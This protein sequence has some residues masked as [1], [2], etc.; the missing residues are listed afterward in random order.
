MDETDMGITPCDPTFV[1]NPIVRKRKPPQR[2]NSDNAK[3][4]T[5]TLTRREFPELK[6]PVP[7]A[8]PTNVG[9]P[10]SID[11]SDENL[12][13]ISKS[14]HLPAERR[15]GWVLAWIIETHFNEQVVVRACEK[16]PFLDR[17]ER[18]GLGDIMR[19]GVKPRKRCAIL[20]AANECKNA[21]LEEQSQRRKI[22]SIA[23]SWR[24]YCSGIKC[25]AANVPTVP[26]NG[27]DGIP[28]YV[29]V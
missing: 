14:L 2:S 13:W 8:S 9:P 25:F 26:C 19:F 1:T 10:S 7:K 11:G 16:A 29:D 4:A 18:A 27:T 5:S 20:A 3:K 6:I 12:W 24:S 28:I 23:G 17:M 21:L 22:D 15:N